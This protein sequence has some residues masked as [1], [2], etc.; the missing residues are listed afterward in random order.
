GM[1]TY[2][3]GDPLDS[4]SWDKSEQ[5]VFQRSDEKK[6]YG[7]GHNGFFK[8][9]DGTEDW[10]VYHAND[11]PGDACVGKRTTRVQKFTWNAD[12]TPNFGIPV[13]T[14]MDIPNPSGDNGKDPLP[15][16]AQVPGIHLAAFDDPT[17]FI[18]QLSGRA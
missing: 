14:T 7:P 9:P 15:Q 13:A 6:V 3:G 1:L 11:N 12:G 10:I 4:H 17:K 2:N 5:P 16:R 8:S 18:N